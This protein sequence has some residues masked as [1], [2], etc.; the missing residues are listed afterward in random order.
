MKL[1]LLGLSC[2]LLLATGAAGAQER[3]RGAVLALTCGGCHGTDGESPGAMPLI[4][5]HDR[6]YIANAMHEFRS[7]A[8]PSTVMGR[9]ARGYS[10]EQIALMAA[11]F[12]R[13]K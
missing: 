13:L 1:K 12:D 2:A 3:S 9:I 11:Y 6:G 4:A 8:R 10:D 5:G 7:G